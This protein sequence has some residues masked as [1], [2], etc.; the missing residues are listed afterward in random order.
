MHQ[1]Q[2]SKKQI[3]FNIAREPLLRYT[4]VIVLATTIILCTYS[5]YFVFP[6]FGIQLANY[7]E[8][9]AVRVGNHLKETIPLEN[10]VLTQDTFTR[11]IQI[12]IEIL[13]QNLQIEKIKIFS[14]NGTILFSSDPEDIGEKNR[15]DYFYNLIAKGNVYSKIVKENARTMEGRIVGR[16]VV[17]SYVPFMADG[18]FQGAAEVYYDITRN[19]I[20]LDGLLNR[21]RISILIFSAIFLSVLFI[22][23]L[24]ASRNRIVSKNAEISL[25]KG[26]AALEHTVVKKTS[27]LK[28]TNIALRREIDERKNAEK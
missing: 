18:V 8:D 16:E 7:T 4:L 24:K 5:F 17:E 28:K 19:R 2:I 26:H 27:D 11:D 20:V 6:Q 15:H 1:Q 25:Q 21:L 23:L 9:T 22:V 10:N 14:H 3:L 12:E 13:M